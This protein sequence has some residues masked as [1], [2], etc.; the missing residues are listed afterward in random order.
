METVQNGK[1]GIK[2]NTNDTTREYKL[3]RVVTSGSTNDYEWFYE[4]LRVITSCS[5]N[6]YE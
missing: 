2:R 6:D 3:L 4:L 5:T 1:A